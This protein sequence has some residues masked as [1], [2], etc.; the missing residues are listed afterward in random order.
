MQGDARRLRQVLVNLLT[1][2]VKYTASGSVTLRAEVIGEQR[3][4]LA[5]EDTGQGIPP[6]LLRRVFDPFFQVTRGDGN[7]AGGIGLGLGIARNLVEAMGGEL[8]L[9][10]IEGQGS[11][12]FFEVELPP[13]DPPAEAAEADGQAGG[14]TTKPIVL[15]VEDDEV[16]RLIASEML[17]RCGWQLVEADTGR[18][19]LARVG[20]QPAIGL[21]LMDLGLPDID[22]LE[23]TRLIRAMDGPQAEV[24][25]IGLTARAMQQD[26]DDCISAGMNDVVLKPFE[27]PRLLKAMHGALS[28]HAERA[29]RA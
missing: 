12:F 8:R 7:G 9:S 17:G 24:P 10:S 29:H 4:L 16:N 11:R 21:V 22:G 6:A 26:H 23:V 18:A 2:G 28:A 15:L 19:A 1:N 14:G 27:L 5:V 13:T 25:I 20:Q 3:L